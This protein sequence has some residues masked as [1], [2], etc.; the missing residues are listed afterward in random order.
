MLFKQALEQQLYS[1]RKT[2][3]SNR[4]IS[5][6]FVPFIRSRTITFSAYGLRPNTRVYAFFDNIDVSTYVT[7][8]AVL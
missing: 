1:N 4:V 7:P 8:N 3:F 5:V 2:K 6:P